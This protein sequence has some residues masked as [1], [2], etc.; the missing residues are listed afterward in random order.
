MSIKIQ[1][2]FIKW[3]GGKTQIMEDIIKN[4]PEDVKNKIKD[5]LKKQGNIKQNTLNKEIVLLN[6]QK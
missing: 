5:I 2:P 1:K 3:V 6:K 4:I